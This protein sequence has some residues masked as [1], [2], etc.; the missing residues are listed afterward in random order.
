M[1]YIVDLQILQI[2]M[3]KGRHLDITQLNN[4]QDLNYY[5]KK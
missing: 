4:G 3:G 5:F 2:N 1:P